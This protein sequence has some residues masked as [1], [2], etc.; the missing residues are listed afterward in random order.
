VV[1]GFVKDQAAPHSVERLVFIVA[2]FFIGA[3]AGICTW[4]RARVRISPADGGERFLSPSVVRYL[5]ELCYAIGLASLVPLTGFV[6]LVGGEAL[7]ILRLLRRKDSSG[8][9]SRP[10][11]PPERAPIGGR[12]RSQWGE[13]ARREAVKWGILVTMTVFVITLEDRYADVLAVT[14]FLLGNSLNARIFG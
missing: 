12:S 1:W 6:I 3:G 4:A 13:A 9:S 7:R 8:Q 5:G 14:S 11:L 10:N 2:T